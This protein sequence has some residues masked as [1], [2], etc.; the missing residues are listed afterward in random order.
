M[1]RR[2]RW[3]VSALFFTNGALFS[4]LLP[5]LPELKSSLD[6]TSGQLGLALLGIGLGGLVGSLATRWLLPRAHSRRAAVGS[7]L[8]L[9]AGSVLSPSWRLS[10][11]RH[12][13]RGVPSTWRKARV[14]ARAW[15]GW[16]SPPS[17]P[18]WW[19][20]VSWPTR[21]SSDGV[22]SGSCGSAVWRAASAWQPRWCS[23]ERC[24]A[25]WPSPSWGWDRPRSSQP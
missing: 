21:S 17:S 10:S 14:L 6:M 18:A 4:S 19:S 22:R 3:A 20:L 5:R 2:E 24:P 1:P 23:A 16:G 8:V 11:R 25:S 13:T 15:P 12:R 9:A 7:T